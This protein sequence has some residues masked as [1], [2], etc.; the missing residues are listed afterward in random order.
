MLQRG[1][2]TGKRD[3]INI[4]ERL[5]NKAITTCSCTKLSLPIHVRRKARCP[6]G[7]HKDGTQL[8]NRS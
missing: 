8:K 1:V 7:G 5:T 4:Q 3:V 6:L 2:K